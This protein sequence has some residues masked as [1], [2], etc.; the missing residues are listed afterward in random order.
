MGVHGIDISITDIY[1]RPGRDIRNRNRHLRSTWR[2]IAAKIA[3]EIATKITL[4]SLEVGPRTRKNDS[5][6]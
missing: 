5:Y 4:H 2:Q 3:T 6:F 1:G